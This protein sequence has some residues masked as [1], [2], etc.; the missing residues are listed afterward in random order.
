MSKISPFLWFDGQAE[1]AMNFYT[2]VFKNSK[3]LH[4]HRIGESG[5]IVLGSFEVDGQP[6]MVLDGGPAHAGFNMAISFMV[7]CDDQAE[8]DHLWLN[9]SDGGKEMQCGWVTDKFGVTWQIVPRVLGELM[10]DPDPVRSGRV[11]QAMLGMKKFIIA[12]LFRAQA[13]G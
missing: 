2:T 13:G 12:D 6:F 7:N 9:L 1:A 5:G 11:M 4:I 8:I 3:I 10:G